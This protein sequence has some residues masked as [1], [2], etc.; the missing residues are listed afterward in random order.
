MWEKKVALSR[1]EPSSERQS[2]WVDSTS[3]GFADV[4]QRNIQD[5]DIYL[6]S[7]YPFQPTIFALAIRETG[8]MR[9][10]HQ[11]GPDRAPKG[12]SLCSVG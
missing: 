7:V 5:C 1:H 11:H 3:G 9:R 6:T 4:R 12:D 8:L 2:F 10:L